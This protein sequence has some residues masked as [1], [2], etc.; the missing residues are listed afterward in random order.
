ME[1][2]IFKELKQLFCKHELVKSEVVEFA[3]LVSDKSIKAI[4]VCR[5]CGKEVVVRYR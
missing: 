3:S 2:K 5:K 4:Y 1:I